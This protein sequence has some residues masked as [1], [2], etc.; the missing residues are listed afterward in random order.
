MK[1]IEDVK[2]DLV[3]YLLSVDKSKLSMTDLRTYCDIVKLVDS[4]YKPE[5]VEYWKDIFQTVNHG[6]G[7]NYR[8]V[9]TKEV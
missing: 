4:L 1:T 6:F 7:S 3:T 9:E 8:P 2:N 5:P